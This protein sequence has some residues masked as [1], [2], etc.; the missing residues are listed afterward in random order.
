MLARGKTARHADEYRERAEKLVAIILGARLSD[1]EPGRKPEA[2]QRAARKLADA[3][4]SARLSD[5]TA[6]RIQAALA[7]L[8]DAGKANQTVNHYRAALRAFVRWAW[9]RGRL[10]DNPM[11][12]VAGYNAEE[13]VRHPRRSLTVG[14]LALLI[15]TAEAGPEL[16]NMPGPLRA[17]AYRVAAATGFRAEELRTLTPESFRLDGAEPT[18]FLRADATKDRR[19]ADQPI[20]LALARTL[21]GGSATSPPVSS[22]SPSI[23]RR[24]RRSAATRKP[25]ASPATDEGVADFHSLRAYYVSALVRSGASIKEVQALARHAKPRR[26]STTTPRFPSATSAARWR[27]CRVPRRPNTAPRPWKQQ[28]LPENM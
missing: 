5:L 10:R 14:E 24:P 15:A 13:D 9:D 4:A 16:F 7:A 23:T 22:S 21:P 25:P 19:P 20:P 26:P 28:G 8:R 2:L 27:T 12:G 3:L 18:V 1:L 6:E 17:M 11:R